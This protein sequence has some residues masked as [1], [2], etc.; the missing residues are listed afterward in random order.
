MT[1]KSGLF[2]LL[3]IAV[4]ADISKADLI[5]GET[6]RDINLVDGDAPQLFIVADSAYDK[7]NDVNKFKINRMVNKDNINGLVDEEQRGEQ[8]IYIPSR[9]SGNGKKRGAIL[10]WTIPTNRL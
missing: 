5:S 2:K 6:P 9:L 1:T 7:R 8:L 3:L 4:I 10:S